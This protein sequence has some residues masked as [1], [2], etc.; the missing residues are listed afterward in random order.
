V[1]RPAGFVVSEKMTFFVLLAMHIVILV[2]LENI[3]G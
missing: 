3:C 2:F 1:E